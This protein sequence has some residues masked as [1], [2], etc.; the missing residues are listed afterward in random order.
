MVELESCSENVV[1]SHIYFSVCIFT[2]AIFVK[3][4][5]EWV[6][7]RV[8]GLVSKMLG[9]A[10]AA[11]AAAVGGGGVGGKRV[12]RRRQAGASKFGSSLKPFLV[13]SNALNLT[14]FGIG[15]SK[16]FIPHHTLLFF[17]KFFLNVRSFRK[18]I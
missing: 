8:E 18:Y 11:V 10:Q 1:K 5:S 16:I 2:R 15:R 7:K 6:A 17:R 9:V 4:R 14:Q 12:D 13:S 3:S